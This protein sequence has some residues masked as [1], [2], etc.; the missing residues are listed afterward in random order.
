ME[1]ARRRA[2]LP[3]LDVAAVGIVLAAAGY[4][5]DPRR[6]DPIDGLRGAGEAGGL[7][8]HAG[9]VGG[10]AGTFTTDGGRVLTVVGR[11]SDLE[12]AREAAKRAAGAISW[13]GMQRRHDIAAS[14]PG[15]VGAIA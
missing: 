12:A 4:P 2:I 5:G 13:D 1:A 15:R 14:L 6:G 11:G 3:A 9:T 8:F 10:G 7:V